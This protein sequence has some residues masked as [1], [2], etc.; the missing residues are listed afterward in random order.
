MNDW[1]HKNTYIISGG[2]ILYKGILIV[3][4]NSI[5]QL[6]MSD[7]IGG[8]YIKKEVAQPLRDLSN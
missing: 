4:N 6:P 5:R 3:E 7:V 8:I 2:T 1:K